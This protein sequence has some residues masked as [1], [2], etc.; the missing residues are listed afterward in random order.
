MV[1]KY[2]WEV[3]L[4]VVLSSAF[5]QN[6]LKIYYQNELCCNLG[7]T[8]L[9]NRDVHVL[10]ILQLLQL[11]LFWNSITKKKCLRDECE[12]WSAISY[13]RPLISGS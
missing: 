13:Q 10:T 9:Y 6:L 11:K 2:S 7:N 1:K 3:K 5:R 4:P 12:V 8:A